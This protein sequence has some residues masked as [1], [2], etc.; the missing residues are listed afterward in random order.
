M[1]DLR[2]H[3][4]LLVKEESQVSLD[5]LDNQDNLDLQDNVVK[6]V[7]QDPKDHKVLKDLEVNPELL[8][9]MDSQVSEENLD[10]QANREVLVHK[11]LKDHKDREDLQVKLVKLDREESLDP[12][13]NRVN[14][15]EMASDA[16]AKC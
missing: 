2:D 15:E 14:L 11:D 7:H 6:M 12:K 3:K 4:D 16:S 1:Q 8:V 5:P 9:L 10:L 13:D